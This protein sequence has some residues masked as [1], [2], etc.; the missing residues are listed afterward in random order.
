MSAS[1]SPLWREL[2]PGWKQSNWHSIGT[3]GGDNRGRRHSSRRVRGPPSDH[4][5]GSSTPGADGARGG[6]R[7]VPRA[8]TDNRGL[9]WADADGQGLT[10]K[11]AWLRIERAGPTGLPCLAQLP[12]RRL[13]TRR[14]VRQPVAPRRSGSE[15]RTGR[16]TRT[17]PPARACGVKVPATAHRQVLAD[18]YPSITRRATLRARIDHGHRFAFPRE[19]GR[20]Q[21]Y[22]G[23]PASRSRSRLR[24]WTPPTSILTKC[25][26]MP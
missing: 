14:Q 26:S 11:A 21:Q 13:F 5:A 18:I 3:A 16:A 2:R 4:T 8:I 23:A 25:S 22:F 15:G 20:T 7:G 12:R 10:K 24:A 6:R 17:P 1:D 19:F 9:K